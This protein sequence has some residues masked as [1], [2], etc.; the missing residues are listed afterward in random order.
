MPATAL[1][2]VVSDVPLEGR[3]GAEG[4]REAELWM[5]LREEQQLD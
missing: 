3:E 5:M 4:A 2:S 1:M